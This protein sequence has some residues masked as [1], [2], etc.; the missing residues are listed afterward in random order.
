MSSVDGITISNDGEVS[1]RVMFRF[2]SYCSA[3]YYRYSRVGISVYFY[4][5]PE[6]TNDCCIY[7]SV[8]ETERITEFN[9]DNMETKKTIDKSSVAI[10]TIEKDPDAHKTILTSVETSVWKIQVCRP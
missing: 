6:E 2:P 8:T 9:T 3:D 10:A 1:A 4:R 7:L 5:Y